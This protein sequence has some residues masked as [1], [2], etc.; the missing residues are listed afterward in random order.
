LTP[1]PL[2]NSKTSH[3][4]SLSTFDL[5]LHFGCVRRRLAGENL[6]AMHAHTTLLNVAFPPGRRFWNKDCRL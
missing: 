5:G 6:R 3:E 4:M 1:H 2:T